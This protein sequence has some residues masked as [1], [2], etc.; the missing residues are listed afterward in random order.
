VNKLNH[1]RILERQREVTRIS[2]TFTGKLMQEAAKRRKNVYSSYQAFSNFRTAT[3]NSATISS[4]LS[5]AMWRFMI[6]RIRSTLVQLNR[7][8]FPKSGAGQNDGHD[9]AGHLVAEVCEF[10]T[11]SSSW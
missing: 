8:K 6:G 7:Q 9:K 2:L 1:L 4:L 11:G 10:V 3:R 5:L